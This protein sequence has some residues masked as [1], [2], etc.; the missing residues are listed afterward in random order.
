M[1]LL[2]SKQHNYR[3]QAKGHPAGPTVHWLI[4]TM[5]L[6]EKVTDLTVKQNV[7]K[8]KV[9]FNP[10]L[11]SLSRGTYEFNTTQE[12][13]GESVASFVGGLHKITEF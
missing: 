9:H 1:F 8:A 4:K 5:P 11:L 10:K 3:G 2:D 12:E 13:E 7:A 6:P